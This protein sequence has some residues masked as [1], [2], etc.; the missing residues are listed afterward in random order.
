MAGELV[1]NITALKK[2]HLIYCKC[3]SQDKSSFGS[4]PPP[5]LLELYK[6]QI[7]TLFSLINTFVSHLDGLTLKKI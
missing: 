7:M 2:V 6:K 1:Y 5:P 3:C 4:P